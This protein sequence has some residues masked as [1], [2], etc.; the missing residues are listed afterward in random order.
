MVSSS[1]IQVPVPWPGDLRPPELRGERHVTVAT[2]KLYARSNP[3]TTDNNLA[4]AP[5]QV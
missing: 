3:L 4:C 2:K 5:A 1:E